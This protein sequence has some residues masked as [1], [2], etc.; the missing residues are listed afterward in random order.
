M[1]ARM[2]RSPSLSSSSRPAGCGG[3]GAA[4]LPKSL[5]WRHLDSLTR[6]RL[7]A[8]PGSGRGRLPALKLPDFAKRPLLVDP[9]ADVQ[10]FRPQRG[11]PLVITHRKVAPADL[12]PHQPAVAF[13]GS[14]VRF[15]N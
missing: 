1:P 12:A 3:T 2:G 5:G 15:N 6:C 9:G 10:E 4:A 14:R 8:G 13:V 7:G 11:G